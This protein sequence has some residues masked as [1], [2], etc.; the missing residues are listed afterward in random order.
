MD[1]EGFPENLDDAERVP[2]VTF[3]EDKGFLSGKF[4]KIILSGA[5]GLALWKMMRKRKRS[6][7]IS[8]SQADSQDRRPTLRFKNP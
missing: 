1:R 5:V 3:E 7:V 6:E 4:A 2:Y 8:E